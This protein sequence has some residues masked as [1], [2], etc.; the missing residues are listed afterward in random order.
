MPTMPMKRITGA[1]QAREIVR[2]ERLIAKSE[3]QIDAGRACLVMGRRLLRLA[4]R[5]LIPAQEADLGA[6]LVAASMSRKPAKPRR[7]KQETR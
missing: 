3:A 2:L 7:A 4:E 1:R 6:M 5:G